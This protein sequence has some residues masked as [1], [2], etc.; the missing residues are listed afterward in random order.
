[1]IGQCHQLSWGRL[2]IWDKMFSM[3]VICGA[4]LG[5]ASVC[6]NV[7]EVTLCHEHL[8]ELVNFSYSEGYNAAKKEL[9]NV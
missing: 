3:E 7:C 4:I 2:L 1:M 9:E 5:D 8:K 6:N